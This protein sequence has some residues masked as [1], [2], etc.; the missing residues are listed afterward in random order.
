MLNSASL[1]DDWYDEYRVSDAEIGPSDAQIKEAGRESVDSAW[2]R[3]Q[4]DALEDLVQAGEALLE[5]C[6]EDN[7]QEFR[8]ALDRAHEICKKALWEV[9]TL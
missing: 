6:T 8:A 5:S 3:S 1:G 9:T 2:Y 4:R 7:E